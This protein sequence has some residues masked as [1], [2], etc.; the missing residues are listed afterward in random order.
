MGVTKAEA[1]AGD[2]GKVVDDIEALADLRKEPAWKRFLSHIG[3][4]FMVCLAYLDPGNSNIL[5]LNL[6]SHTHMVSHA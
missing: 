6:F 3:P 1:V 5:S 2:G 4:G